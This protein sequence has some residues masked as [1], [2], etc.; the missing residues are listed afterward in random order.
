MSAWEGCSTLVDEHRG[1]RVA[2]FVLVFLL[3][4][5]DFL[6]CFHGLPF[7]VMWQAL[8]KGLRV[9]GLFPK[10]LLR[11]EGGSVFVDEDEVMKFLAV[12]FYYKR[13]SAFSTTGTRAE[14]ILDKQ[15][16]GQTTSFVNWVRLLSWKM[17]GTRPRQMV[18]PADTLRYQVKRAGA[19][20]EYWVGGMAESMPHVEFKGRGWNTA[21]G[22]VGEAV[23]H[24]N[25][26]LNLSEHAYIDNTG[27]TK[28]LVCGCN[29]DASKKHKCRR[30]C[31][32]ARLGKGCHPILCGCKGQCDPSTYAGAAA[33]PEVLRWEVG[34]QAESGINGSGEQMA[35]DDDTD[36][37][38]DSDACS[39]S[40]EDSGMGEVGGCPEEVTLD[41]RRAR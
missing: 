11:F 3:T 4:G 10:A 40:S 18:P 41:S 12:A 36:C 14:D 39:E 13:E 38:S 15:A 22:K 17:G 5:C 7:L 34:G 9:P 26:V 35:V 19:V 23:T 27:K 6:P 2:L 20:L 8:L 32:C 37:S 31:T 30:T 16:E 24:D 28:N 25:I 29:P 33:Y 1:T 21:S